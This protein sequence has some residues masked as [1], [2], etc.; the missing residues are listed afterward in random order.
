MLAAMIEAD[1]PADERALRATASS[2]LANDWALVLASAGISHRLVEGAGAFTLVVD[3]GDAGPAAAALD[4]YDAES[5]PA[6]VPPAPDL[7][8]SALGVAAGVVLLA[9]FVVAGPRA[10]STPSVWF[11]VGNAS[12]ELILRGEWWRTLT[13]LTLHGDLFHL[14]A[15]VVLCLLF[16]S[17]VG[18]W[19]GAGLGAALIV[20]SAATA[21]FLTALRHREHFS[22][23]GASTAMFTALGIVVGLQF[24]RRWR[25]NVRRRYA[26]LPLG[27]GLALYA[28][29]GAGGRDMS[30]VPL[31]IDT[32]AHLF[33]LGVGAATGTAFAATR[34]KTPGRLGQTLLT[35]AVSAVLVGAWVVA[36]RATGRVPS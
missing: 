13:A 19:L 6:L 32:W 14:L 4:A 18:R 25:S 10:A 23:V 35:L 1:S 36:F 31:P 17:A 7:G 8:P 33:G 20:S 28:M 34:V 2:T 5:V 26:W 12:A 9:M 21:N 29:L 11:D 22:S 30:G 3:A 27:A 16:V 24:V 15:N